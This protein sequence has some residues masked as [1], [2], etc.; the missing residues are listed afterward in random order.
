MGCAMYISA[1]FLDY[2]FYAVKDAAMKLHWI[3]GLP[4]VEIP[5]SGEPINAASDFSLGDKPVA[6]DLELELT[7]EG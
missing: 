2:A 5:A 3:C 4:Y 7:K 1:G 6:E